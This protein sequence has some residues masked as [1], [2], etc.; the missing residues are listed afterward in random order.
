MESPMA[1]FNILYMTLA[2][3]DGWEC[4]LAP[5]L[6]DRDEALDLFNKTMAKDKNLGQFTFDNNGPSSDYSLV[7]MGNPPV[8]H[9]LYY[10]N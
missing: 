5:I 4:G 9:S 1:S 8:Y 3:D 10:K 2:D 7:E 6:R